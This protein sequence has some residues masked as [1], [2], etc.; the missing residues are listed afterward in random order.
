MWL[1]VFAILA[2]MMG[3]DLYQRG[4]DLSYASVEG[5][6]TNL[7]GQ[8]AGAIGAWTS[9]AGAICLNIAIWHLF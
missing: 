2:L 9:F 8:D 5:S 4:C 7:A 6:D 1:L 3:A